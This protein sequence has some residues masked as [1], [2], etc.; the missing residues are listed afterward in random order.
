[1]KDKILQ[2]W[3]SKQLLPIHLPETNYFV[4]GRLFLSTK[5]YKDRDKTAI[6]VLG[7]LMGQLNFLHQAY[8]DAIEKP[9]GHLFLNLK[10]SADEKAR[11]GALIL[12]T[13][14]V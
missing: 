10:S 8:M 1:M 11:V 7:S 2:N 6:K 13:S 5:N 14:L 4:T 3:W 9:F 12:L